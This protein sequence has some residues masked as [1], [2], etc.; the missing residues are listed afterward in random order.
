MHT[1]DCDTISSTSNH[2][3]T[4]SGRTSSKS[5]FAGAQI[6]GEL[7]QEIG[8]LGHSM[9]LSDHLN[10]TPEDPED[11]DHQEKEY[12]CE[13]CPKTF[14]WKS[15]LIRHQVS[16]DDSRNY[17]CENCNKVFTD[18]SNLQRHIRSQHIG[19]RSHACP[20]C[21]KTFATSSGLKQHMHIHSSVKP[22]RCEVCLKAYTQFSNLC[23]HKRMH[24]NCRMQVKCYQCG[25]SFPTASSLSKH[26]R[27][28]EGNGLQQD[29]SVIPNKSN[30]LE[31]PEI[32]SNSLKT[33]P[34]SLPFYHKQ[35]CV[36]YPPNIMG[37]PMFPM[38]PL[39]SFHPFL[40]NNQF[41]T[42][43]N[44][45]H[46]NQ[47]QAY[48]NASGESDL[49]PLGSNYE[50]KDSEISEDQRSDGEDVSM[51]LSE[52]EED[53]SH[54][55]DNNNCNLKY[56]SAAEYIKEPIAF[57][58]G[59]QQT[60]NVK[61][62]FQFFPPSSKKLKFEE[63][64]LTDDVSS[65]PFDLSRSS[66]NKKT[67]DTKEEI[68]EIDN[69]L[70]SDEPL[71]LRVTSSKDVPDISNDKIYET[72]TEA[73]NLKKEPQKPETEEKTLNTS[74]KNGDKW[75]ITATETNVVNSFNR[76]KQPQ[77]IL[78]QF[79]N[80]LG[81]PTVSM[82][83]RGPLFNPSFTS[84]AFSPFGYISSYFNPGKGILEDAS[85]LLSRK[86]KERYS[87][88]FCGKVFPRSAN[89]TRHLRTHT[90]EQPYKCKYCERSFSISS[91][92]QR[93]V[94]NI[95]NKEK[96]FKCSLCDRSFGQQ[97][98]LER[99]LKKHE[100]TL[101][102]GSL[103]VIEEDEDKDPQIA[104]ASPN[105]PKSPFTREVGGNQSSE[106]LYS[107][108]SEEEQEVD[109]FCE[110]I[111]EAS[112]KQSEPIKPHGDCELGPFETKPEFKGTP[113]N[114]PVPSRLSW[115]VISKNTNSARKLQ[116]R[117][118]DVVNKQGIELTT[119]TNTEGPYAT[120]GNTYMVMV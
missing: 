88:K 68:K 106:S 28:C 54:L 51:S 107:T 15:N 101:F 3:K 74:L 33:T 71:D 7:K 118:K 80:V 58:K 2:E 10:T 104:T 79:S 96:P 93:H 112:I 77:N 24:V 44:S 46:H 61:S 21:G 18:P 43:I 92:L 65:V 99:H 87:C 5:L 36:N 113:L 109:M 76:M 115:N 67:S 23:R 119:K 75:L 20:D 45:L 40:P 72:K 25:Q 89:L 47:I 82:P 13:K 34:T 97:T 91:N 17:M 48:S 100:S 59:Y 14:N 57:H 98:N 19:A 64:T 110:E 12:K 120:T 49:T 31:S 62:P 69:K 70:T 73:I 50:S 38:P 27:F 94:R 52:E 11:T 16:H 83:Y 95:H 22:F 111:G 6:V 66:T 108:N 85:P 105:H 29:D 41:S 30:Y 103:S 26:K 117:E 35:L 86:H 114:S 4:Q 116:C 53:S 37:C 55:S 90:G 42:A 84:G 60:K 39:L 1:D 32:S 63:N 9:R 56:D 81:P 8:V 78:P 102:D